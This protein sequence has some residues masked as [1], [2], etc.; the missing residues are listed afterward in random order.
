MYFLACISM[1]RLL[2]RVHHLLFD[3]DTGVNLDSARFPGMVQELDLQLDEWRELL[4]HF[5][6]FTVDT[7]QPQISVLRF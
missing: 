1:R 6:R 5:F 7:S 2:N 4:L 3:K